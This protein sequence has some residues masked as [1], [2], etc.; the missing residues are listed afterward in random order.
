MA[1]SKEE[2]Q[3]ANRR[4]TTHLA[5]TPTAQTARYDH[6]VGCLIVDLSSG[7]SIS[8]K[9]QDAEGLED[10][11]PEQLTNIV[12]SPSGLGLHF[13]ILMQ[14]FTYPDCY[15]ASSALAGGWLHRWVRLVAAQPHAPRLTPFGQ[16][17][18]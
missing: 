13:P 11:R 12:I 4:A 2:V 16:T 17:G 8:F 14:I 7:L 15:K 9:P 1:Y 18:S 6:S 10:A 3:A 5:K